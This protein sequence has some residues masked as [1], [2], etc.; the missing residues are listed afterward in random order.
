MEL[1]NKQNYFK[2]KSIDANLV[3]D[4]IKLLPNDLQEN[5]FK[6]I[7]GELSTTVKVGDKK[8]F[9]VEDY[10]ET[11]RCCH[12][13]CEF[14]VMK[15]NLISGKVILKG[16]GKGKDIHYDINYDVYVG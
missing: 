11:G 12:F 10:D 6:F 3:E 13:E 14:E 16:K 2:T 7:N 4:M 1:N 15:I 9:E 8:I 5:C